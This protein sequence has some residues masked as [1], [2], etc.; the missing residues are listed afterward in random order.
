[1]KRI[2]VCM[3]GL[4]AAFGPSMAALAQQDLEVT[5]DVVPANTAPGAVTGEIRL[6]A[7]AAPEGHQNSAFGLDTANRA[8]TLKSE[9]G[10]RF[11][12]DTAAA[13]RERAQERIPNIGPP[14][15]RP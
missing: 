13:A 9:L 6:P 8:R 15:G 5:M 10:E 4:A 11:G 14:R 2:A 7:E 3:I 12:Q 1:M